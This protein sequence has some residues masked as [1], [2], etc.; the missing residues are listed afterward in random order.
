MED[1]G[2][3]GGRE[4]DALFVCVDGHGGAAA[5]DYFVGNIAYEVGLVGVV[6]L[7]VLTCVRLYIQKNTKMNQD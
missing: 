2:G 6:V 4:G 1:L 5:A 3:V 7:T